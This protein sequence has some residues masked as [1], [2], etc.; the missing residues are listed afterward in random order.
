M[1]NTTMYHRFSPYG[2]ARSNFLAAA[3]RFLQLR[4]EL[5]KAEEL[6]DLEHMHHDFVTCDFCKQAHELRNQYNHFAEHFAYI[7]AVKLVET[8]P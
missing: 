1:T 5:L 2:F 6:C 7:W 4:E 3:E 8:K